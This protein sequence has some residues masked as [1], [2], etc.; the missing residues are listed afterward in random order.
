PPRAPPPPPS[1]GP[2][3][4]PPR[5]VVLCEPGAFLRRLTADILRQAGAERITAVDD[6]EA[7]LWFMRHTRRAVLIAG[8]S[9]A[10]GGPDA[11]TLVRKLRQEPGPA[12]LAPTLIVSSRRSFEDIER[13]RDSGVDALALRP[14][15]PRDVT[16]RLDAA[17]ARTRAFV[18]S[19]AFTGPDRRLRPGA[20]A[21]WKRNADIDAGRTT[22]LDAARAQ[23][24]AMVARMRRRRDPL[25][26]RV[27]ASL[28]RCLEDAR[29]LGPVEAEITVLHRATLAKLEDLHAAP[30]GVRAEIVDSLERLAAR[31]Q[32][33]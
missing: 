9:D 33:A 3:A 14:A 26:A 28:A 27:G 20:D 1:P 29:T 31:R 22:P 11:A 18:R 21:A 5:P 8:W 17:A 12:G 2:A 24:A 13:A 23:A 10:P 16:V 30:R 32:A 6:P 4:R 7:A 15:A 19:D 25:A